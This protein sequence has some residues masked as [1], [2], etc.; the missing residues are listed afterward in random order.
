MAQNN[1][2]P[3]EVL[4]RLVTATKA[5][6]ELPPGVRPSPGRL[7][8]FAAEGRITEYRIGRNMLF[9]PEEVRALV[10]RIA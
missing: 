8:R 4:A 2:I 9:D 6:E 3:P 7:R 1:I 5:I 10:Q